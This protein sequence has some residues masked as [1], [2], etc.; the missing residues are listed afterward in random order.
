MEIVLRLL[1]QGGTM[2]KEKFRIFG[3][4]ELGRVGQKVTRTT[5]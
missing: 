1:L 3:T 4:I 2:N 5:L